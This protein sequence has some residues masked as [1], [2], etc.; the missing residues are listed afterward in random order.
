MLGVLVNVGAI[1]VGGVIGLLFKKGINEQVKNVVMQAMGLSVMVI[2]IKGSIETENILLLV[3]SLAIGGIIGASIGIERRLNKLGENIENRY[4]SEGQFAKGF[5]LAT[6]IYC[7]GAMAIL[8]SIDAGFGDN[9]TLYV[10]SI[11]D[12]VTAIIFTATLGYGVIFSFIP[13]LI[14]QGLIVILGQY[15]EPFLTNEL[16][17][18]MSA[19]GNVIILGIG[20]N[21]LNIKKIHVGDL[22]PAI[23]IP[24]IYFLLI[25]PIL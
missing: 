7:V 15:I 24:A 9:S 23:F 14:Y 2:G 22:L 17:I 10:K 8:G 1:I 4:S 18:E 6:L 12:G 25:F 20:L 21:L 11:L 3:L 13:V 16:I 5:V 19:V